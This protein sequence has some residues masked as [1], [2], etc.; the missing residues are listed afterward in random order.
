MKI[1]VVP[2]DPTHDQYILKP[3]VERIFKD[4]DTG[5]RIEVLKDPHLGGGPKRWTA[6]IMR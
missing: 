4:L 1:L 5:A 2:E 3:I 6:R